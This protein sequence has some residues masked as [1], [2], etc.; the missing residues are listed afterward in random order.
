[1]CLERPSK[2][3]NGWGGSGGDLDLYHIGHISLCFYSDRNIEPL[4]GFEQSNDIRQ[5][6]F[7]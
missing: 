5:L 2:G 4:H 1:M 3:K 6:K 7:K